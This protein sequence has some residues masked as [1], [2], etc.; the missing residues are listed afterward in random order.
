MIDYYYDEDKSQEDAIPTLHSAQ[1]IQSISMYARPAVDTLGSA[2]DRVRY[3]FTPQYE[4]HATWTGATNDVDPSV[5]MEEPPI[6]P[7]L[8]I[9]QVNDKFEQVKSKC[10]RAFRALRE[11]QD[12]VT[13]Q[14][15][16][17]ALQLCLGKIVCPKEAQHFTR[18][19]ESGDEHQIVTVYDSMNAC[20][21]T[22]EASAQAVLRQ[23]AVEAATKNESQQEV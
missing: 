22:F 9:E 10:Q 15:A 1:S 20:I 14:Q 23:Q 11:C 19:L 16:A 13:C 21:E 18:A 3:R 7:R 12:E 8:S 5:D 4:Q 2:W 6:N 17:T